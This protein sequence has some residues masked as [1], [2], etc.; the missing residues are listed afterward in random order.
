MYV[1][2]SLDGS[3]EIEAITLT[4]RAPPAGSAIPRCQGPGDDGRIRADTEEVIVQESA[5]GGQG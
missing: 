2:D 5:K 1:A 4:E 3:S